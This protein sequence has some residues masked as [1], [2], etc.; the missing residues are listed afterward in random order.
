M[1]GAD[2]EGDKRDG[3]ESSRGRSLLVL[4]SEAGSEECENKSNLHHCSTE[5][6]SAFH[7]PLLKPSITPPSLPANSPPHS[8]ALTGFKGSGKKEIYNQY[9][10]FSHPHSDPSLFSVSLQTQASIQLPHSSSSSYHTSSLPNF[11]HCYFSCSLSLTS[12]SPYLPPHTPP[13]L[14]ISFLLKSS[15]EKAQPSNAQN[16]LCLV[17]VDLNIIV[18]P[19][20]LYIGI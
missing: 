4:K 6:S 3:R 9:S 18:E 20:K 17:C 12:P 14:S 19:F 10:Q 13:F 2:E 5:L 7:L 8:T 16:G 11:P 1:D 15:H